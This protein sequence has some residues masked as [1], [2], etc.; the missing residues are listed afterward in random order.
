[1]EKKGIVVHPL[2]PLY[3]AHARVLI[4]GTMPSPKSREKAFYYAHPQNKFWPVMAAVFGCDLPEGQEGKKRMLT[5]RHIA[6]W[7]VLHSCA[8]QGADD[9]TITDVVVNNIADIVEKTSV[10]AIFTTGKKAF[11]LYKKH[12]E[13]Q[14][15]I[16][17]LCLPST[18]PANC[19]FYTFQDL[20]E[21]YKE[22]LKFL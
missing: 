9:S 1:M 7:D 14:T 10:K 3:T 21:Q 18:S 22:I 17:A 8:I 2:G 15:G 4:L 13:Q 20:V 16:K 19:R 5:E 11:S 6:L 12:C